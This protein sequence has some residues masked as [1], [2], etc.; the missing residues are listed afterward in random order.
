MI[1]LHLHLD[2]SL[3]VEDFKYL[4]SRN[5]IPLPSEF[6]NNIYVPDGCKSLEEYLLRFDLPCSLMQDEYSLAYVAYSL[7]NRL[8]KNGYIYAEIRFAPQLHTLKG[9][10]QRDAVISAI[11]GVNK[12]LKDNPGMNANLILCCM[13]QADLKTNMETI[14]LGAEFKGNRVVAVDLAGPEAFKTGDKYVALFNRAKELGLNIT[15]HA[16]EACGSDEVIRAVDLLHAQR[17]GHGV[18]LELNMANIKKMQEKKIAFEFCPT[19]N[20]NTTS[21]SDYE[22]C[23]IR[24]FDRVGICVTVNSDNMT[25]SNTDVL[26]EFRHL[27]KAF[28]LQQHEVRHF[29]SNAIDAAFISVNEKAALLKRLANNIDSYYQ[30]IIEE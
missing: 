17:I 29:L 12:A 7:V 14:E 20:I 11:S 18:H 13:R 10:S 24:E 6:P 26:K 3:S 27:Y 19:S 30:K 25:V 4:A 1:D 28:K 9:M 22:H 8:A 5:N 15:I 16:G 23:P 21:I 2:G